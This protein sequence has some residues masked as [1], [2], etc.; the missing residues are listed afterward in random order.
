M[1]DGRAGPQRDIVLVNAAAA[2]VACGLADGFLEGAVMAAASID[3]GAARGKMKAL[4][5]FTNGH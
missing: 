1:L 5:E 3:S 4:A 2:L